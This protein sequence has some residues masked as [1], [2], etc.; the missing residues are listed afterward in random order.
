MFIDDNVLK[1]FYCFFISCFV[2]LFK[3]VKKEKEKK[4]EKVKKEKD[5]E[6]EKDVLDDI[7]LK[8]I[9]EI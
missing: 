4:E 9:K 5:V 3:R 1:Y 2:E 8:D 6:K 7:I